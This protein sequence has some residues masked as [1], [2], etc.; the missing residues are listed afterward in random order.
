LSDADEDV[1]VRPSESKWCVERCRSIDVMEERRKGLLSRSRV[2]GR[3]LIY[4]GV[5]GTSAVGFAGFPC[6]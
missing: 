1:S 4:C 2:V 3:D 6:P 5:L